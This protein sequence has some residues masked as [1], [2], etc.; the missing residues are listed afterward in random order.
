[1]P[2][3]ETNYKALT[4]DLREMISRRARKI[5]EKSGKIPGRDIENWMQAETEILSERN[6]AVRKSAVIIRI[7]GV[8]YVGEY[9]VGSADGYTPG[10]FAAG[11]AVP[12][13]LV[14]DQMF[15]RRRNG[16]ELVTTL[17]KQAG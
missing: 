6:R 2:A 8:Q 17:L 7:N 5:Y 16:K 10:E 4:N 15:V 1:M 13:R 12:V 11:D 3:S 14:G 9:P